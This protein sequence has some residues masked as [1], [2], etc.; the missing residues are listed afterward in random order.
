MRC[1]EQ[2]RARHSDFHGTPSCPWLSVSFIR[3]PLY[4]VRY[5]AFSIGVFL[6]FGCASSNVSLGHGYRWVYRKHMEGG[7]EGA[8]EGI[9]HYHDLYYRSRLLAKGVGY[10]YSISPSGRFALF[11]DYGNIG[12]VMLFDRQTGEARNVTD[13][14]FVV[15]RD[16]A[17]SEKAGVAHVSYYERQTSSRIILPP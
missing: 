3:C 4:T 15:P 7:E 9:A 16:F 12:R 17:W 11:V 1:T 5:L 2:P 13:G 10:S 6:L 8:F 14:T